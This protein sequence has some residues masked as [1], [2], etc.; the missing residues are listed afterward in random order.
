MFKKTQTKLTYVI[1]T[2]KGEVLWDSAAQ[3]KIDAFVNALDG[4]VNGTEGDELDR[5]FW[6]DDGTYPSRSPNMRAF[7]KRAER[8]GWYAVVAEMKVTPQAVENATWIRR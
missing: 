4:S 5:L 2:P 8:K 6:G 3:T 7:Q 1:V